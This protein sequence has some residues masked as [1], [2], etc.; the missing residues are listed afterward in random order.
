MLVLL[1]AVLYFTEL[2]F[3]AIPKN[4]YEL[5]TLVIF[6]SG[7]LTGTILLWLREKFGT[8]LLIIT[9]VL[10][11]VIFMVIDKE[12]VENLLFMLLLIPPLL[13]LKNSVYQDEIKD[14]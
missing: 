7:V 10:E 4:T 1:F 6:Y 13:V 11:F 5:V 8:A 3:D 9:I 14:V 2:E 12:V